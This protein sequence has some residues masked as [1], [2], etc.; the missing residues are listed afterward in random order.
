MPAKIDFPQE[1]ARVDPLCLMLR[2]WIALADDHARVTAVELWSD[3][4]KLG[5]TT[6]LFP[7]P[8]VTASLGLA[9]ETPTAFEVFGHHP[10][11]AFGSTMTVEIRARLSDGSTTETLATTTL[12]TIDRDYR[13]HHFG[14]LLDRNTT[15]VQR[16]DSIFVTGPSQSEPSPELET[17]VR[18]YL[19]P[20]PQR[21]I[22]VGCGI[23]S[24]G[25]GLRADGYD[26]LGVEIDANDCAELARL[27]LPHRLVDGRTLPF[28]DGSFDAALCLEVLEHVE[29]PAP[30]LAEIK[31]VSPR[32]LILSVPNCELLAYLWP[33]LATPWHM[34]EATHVNYFTR[35]SLAAL[36]RP[37]YPEVELR[38][39][40]PCPLR[41]V[42]STPLHYNLLAIA[43]DPR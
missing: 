42:E 15:R 25:R 14:V 9:P 19:G 40:S 4:T 22:D 26:W 12:R 43:A 35:W 30:F 7:R 37:L 33:Y 17:F 41:T 32:K 18:R 6:A 11:A 8:D 5:E 13:Q 2:G 1:G 34:L 36:L 27:E 20:A 10:E 38:F 21:L 29:D 24:Y 16:E 28:P 39:F 3:R 23:G 31:R